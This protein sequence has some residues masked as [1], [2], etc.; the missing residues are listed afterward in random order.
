MKRERE[1]SRAHRRS[2]WAELREMAD[3]D[4]EAKVAPSRPKANHV[5]NR[6]PAPGHV[7]S[8][9]SNAQLQ[10]EQPEFYGPYVP[11]GERYL[12]PRTPVNLDKAC[13]AAGLDELPERYKGE[14]FFLPRS[15][16]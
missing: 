14:S 7:G 8:Y 13:A 4:R 11:E 3:H 16:V 1:A 6:H 9:H 10:A 5:Y 12:T 2:E 15:Y